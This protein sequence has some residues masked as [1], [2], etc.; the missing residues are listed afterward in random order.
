MSEDLPPGGSPGAAAAAG[1]LARAHGDALVGG[2]RVDLLEQASMLLHEVLEQGGTLPAAA[3]WR[4]GA[5]HH[6]RG[7]YSQAHVYFE[8]GLPDT[9]AD[10]VDRARLLA[11]LASV[12]WAQGDAEDGRR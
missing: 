6:Y 11:G 2:T 7:E 9:T 5:A 10:P 3:A 12:L 1:D 4:I 8:A